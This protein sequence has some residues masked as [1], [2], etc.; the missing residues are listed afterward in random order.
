MD[1]YRFALVN[2]TKQ[3][4]KL[5]KTPTWDLYNL[6][7]WLSNHALKSYN[8]NSLLHSFINPHTEEVNTGILQKISKYNAATCV[9]LVYA[10]AAFMINFVIEYNVQ[11]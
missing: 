5:I 7:Y 10:T 9:H 1:K 8:I 4:S 6:V 3:E 11:H 2:S